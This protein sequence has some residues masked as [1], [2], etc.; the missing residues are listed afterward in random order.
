MNSWNQTE[1]LIFRKI[2]NSKNITETMPLILCQSRTHNLEFSRVLH[3]FPRLPHP[4]EWPEK[5]FWHGGC[6]S[7]RHE[8]ENV[9]KC[10]NIQTISV[11]CIHTI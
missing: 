8:T 10:I 4:L 2:Q 5:D 9:L 6:H 1:L 11:H 7:Q 3:I